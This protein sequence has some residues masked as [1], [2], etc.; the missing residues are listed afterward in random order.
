MTSVL[1]VLVML[2]FGLIGLAFAVDFRGIA[3]SAARRSA[4]NHT[5]D[6][7]ALLTLIQRAIGV[8]F[9]LIAATLIVAVIAAA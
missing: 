8:L 1:P 5:G 2:T 4:W 7:L 3:A 6:R 9:V